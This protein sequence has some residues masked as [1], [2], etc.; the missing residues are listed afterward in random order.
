MKDVESVCLYASLDSKI[1]M[2]V[3]RGLKIPHPKN[4]NT[5]NIKL[6]RMMY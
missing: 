2:E 1:H 5:Y 4:R 3:P 6:Q